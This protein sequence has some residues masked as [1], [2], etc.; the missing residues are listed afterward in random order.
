MSDLYT[1]YELD[2]NISEKSQTCSLID[3]DENYDSNENINIIN[4]AM[5]DGN[6]KATIE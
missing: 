4:S 1:Q 5:D 3:Y 6:I 2:L